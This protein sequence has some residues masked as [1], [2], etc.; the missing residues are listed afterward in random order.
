MLTGSKASKQRKKTRREMLVEEEENDIDVTN[1]TQDS[2]MGNIY[3][4]S[5]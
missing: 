1:E 3:L 2:T 5:C 4:S